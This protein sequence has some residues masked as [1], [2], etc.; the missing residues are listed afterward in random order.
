MIVDVASGRDDPKQQLLV[1]VKNR[2]TPQVALEILTRMR[3]WSGQGV[4]LLCCPAISPRVQQLCEQHGIGYLDAAGNC[5]IAAP[6]LYIERRGLGRVPCEKRRMDLFAPKTSRIVRAMLSHPTRGW[7]VQRLAGW[8]GLGVSQGLA[9]RA[10][11]ALLEQ[12]FAVERDRLLYVRDPDD[13]LKAWV[14]NCRPAIHR[15]PIY[16]MGDPPDAEMA[17]ADW[18]KS[19]GL[20]YAAH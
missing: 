19:N 16:V 11:H 15:I 5:R 3:A 7:Q 12:G 18:C 14:E 8:E 4:P 10:K 13:L 6:G 17:I 1:E 2:V 20:R 9:S